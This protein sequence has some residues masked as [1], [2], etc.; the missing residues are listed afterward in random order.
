MFQ[1][2]VMKNSELNKIDKEAQAKDKGAEERK[3]KAMFAAQKKKEKAEERKKRFL[4]RE[5]AERAACND[6]VLIYPLIPY[7]L[8]FFIKEKF[9]AEERALLKEIEERKEQLL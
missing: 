2:D 9:D 3:L 6:L 5:K 1:E 7:K 8:E 4:D